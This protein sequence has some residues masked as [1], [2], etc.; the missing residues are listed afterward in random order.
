MPLGSAAAISNTSVF[1]TAG[2][3]SKLADH[4]LPNALR[5]PKSLSL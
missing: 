2:L 5:S 4:L 1:K 3:S